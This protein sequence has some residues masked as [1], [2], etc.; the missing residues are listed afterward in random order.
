MTFHPAEP[1][2]CQEGR[3][4][5]EKVYACYGTKSSSACVYFSFSTSSYIKSY[6]LPF[7]TLNLV[8]HV[9]KLHCLMSLS[10]GTQQSHDE[11]SADILQH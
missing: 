2:E 8:C 1:P 4:L 9:E 3:S 5:E 11:T 7:T 10:T 6:Q